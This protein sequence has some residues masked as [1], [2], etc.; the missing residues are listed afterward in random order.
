MDVAGGISDEIVL[1]ATRPGIVMGTVAYMEQRAASRGAPSAFSLLMCAH[2]MPAGRRP[3]IA[4]H[5]P[6]RWRRFS[7]R[8]RALAGSQPASSTRPEGVVAQCLKKGQRERSLRTDLAFQLQTVG[9]RPWRPATTAPPETIDSLAVLPFVNAGGNP[10]TEYPSDG[11]AE[12][13][14]NSLSQVPGSALCRAAGPSAT[15]ARM[16]TL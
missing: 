7:A 1:T 3:S 4:P 13:L 11:I 10:D 16:S 15:K 8:N 9:T 6:R 5:R 14:I 2:E 12:S